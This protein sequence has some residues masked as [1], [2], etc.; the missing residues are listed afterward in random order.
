MK[1]EVKIK[2]II[3]SHYYTRFT[4]DGWSAQFG[5]YAYRLMKCY[6]YGLVQGRELITMASLSV[7]DESLNAHLQIN[8]T[9]SLACEKL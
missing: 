2:Q 9:N 7:N 6:N 1:S 5:F 4:C 8:F 3:K